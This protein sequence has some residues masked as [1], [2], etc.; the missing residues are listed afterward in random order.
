MLSNLVFL[1][2]WLVRFCGDVREYTRG[3]YKKLYFC[4]FL[5]KRKELFKL[6]NKI[7]HTE[8]VNE[9]IIQTIERLENLLKNIKNLYIQKKQIP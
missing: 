4:L 1:V 8:Q 7:A 3:H 2:L 6:E 9:E 5:C